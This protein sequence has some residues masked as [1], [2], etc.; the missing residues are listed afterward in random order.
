M[1]QKSAPGSL[2][3]PHAMA[4][5]HGTSMSQ[6]HVYEISTGA[7]QGLPRSYGSSLRLGCCRMGMRRMSMESTMLC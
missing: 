4:Q 3:R 1:E 2:S 6:I 7:Q 5:Q